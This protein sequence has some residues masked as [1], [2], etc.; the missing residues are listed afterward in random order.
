MV[1]NVD[2]GA[3]GLWIEKQILFVQSSPTLLLFS[4]FLFF[5]FIAPTLLALMTRFYRKLFTFWVRLSGSKSTK[6]DFESSIFEADLVTAGVFC[7]VACCWLV[8]ITIFLFKCIDVFFI[9]G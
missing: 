6:V 8:T 3:I 7:M 4:K 9:N 5:L 2:L 1:I